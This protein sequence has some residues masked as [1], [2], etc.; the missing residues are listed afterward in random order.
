MSEY[1]EVNRASWD[2]RA[3]SDAASPEFAFARFAEDPEDVPRAVDFRWRSGC[4]DQALTRIRVSL[5]VV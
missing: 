3:A 5:V 4:D 2:E 1:R